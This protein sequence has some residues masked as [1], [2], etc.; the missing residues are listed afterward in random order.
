ML[1]LESMRT[2]VLQQMVSGVIYLTKRAFLALRD[3]QHFFRSCHE[4]GSS[5]NYFYVIFLLLSITFP[6]PISTLLQA[7]YYKACALLYPYQFQRVH[8]SLL[9]FKC[10]HNLWWIPARM[11][12]YIPMPTKYAQWGKISCL[13]NLKIIG[14]VMSPSAFPINIFSAYLLCSHRS[15]SSLL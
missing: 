10:S 4:V 14:S 5:W 3:K 8:I 15:P 1:E 12:L 13:T 6:S 2:F 11:W 9:W 7:C